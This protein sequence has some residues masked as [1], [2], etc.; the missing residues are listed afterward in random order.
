MSDRRE[1]FAKTAMYARLPNSDKMNSIAAKRF[2]NDFLIL[3]EIAEGS[4]YSVHYTEYLGVNEE[5]GNIMTR[6]IGHQYARSYEHGK[7]L[8]DKRSAVEPKERA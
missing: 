6:I 2:G 1:K 3:K 4:V 5:N 7:D 8:F